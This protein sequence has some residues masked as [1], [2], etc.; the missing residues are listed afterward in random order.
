MKVVKHNSKKKRLIVI[1]TFLIVAVMAV[2]VYALP[3]NID[4]PKRGKRVVGGRANLREL[5]HFDDVNDTQIVAAQEFGIEPLKTRGQI[6]SVLIASL[7]TVETSNLFFVEKLTHSV[8]YLTNNASDLLNTIAE[9]FQDK[10]RNKG[11]AQYQIIVTSLLRTE[12]DVRRLQ[13]VN[14]NAVRKSCHMYGTTFDIAYNC[15]QQ[16]DSLADFEG[17]VASHKVLVNTL[18]ETLKELRDNER[19]FIKYERR[20]PCFHITARY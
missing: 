7:S 16:V 2:L 6:D 1:F 9:N 20:Q 13:R 17:D 12:D 3:Q 14:R 5:Y 18:G 8:P 15:F 11:L 4:E 10:L 19:C